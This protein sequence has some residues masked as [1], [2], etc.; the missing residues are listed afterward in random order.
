M[1]KRLWL[2]A[3]SLMLTALAQAHARPNDVTVEVVDEHGSTFTQVPVRHGSKAYRAYL[4]AERGV[5]Y[6]IRVT[7]RSGERLGLVMA[8]DGRNIISGAR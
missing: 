5:R 6:R 7:N 3:T 2:A 1:S 8:V 4:Q